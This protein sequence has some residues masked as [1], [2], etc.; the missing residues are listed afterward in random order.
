MVD[1]DEMPDVDMEKDDDD[2][3]KEVNEEGEE[4]EKKPK[5]KPSINQRKSP[6]DRIRVGRVRFSI[7]YF[8]F[9][10]FLILLIS[11][12]ATP[13]IKRVKNGVKLC[14]LYH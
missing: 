6:D 8:D 12:V 9:S 5:V 10:T 7:F 14:L 3:T 2:E 11:Y 4:I 1:E 13:L